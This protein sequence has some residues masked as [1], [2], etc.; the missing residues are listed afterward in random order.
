MYIVYCIVVPAQVKKMRAELSNLNHCAVP[1]AVYTE[2]CTASIS[3]LVHKI[4][5][6]KSISEILTVVISEDIVTHLTA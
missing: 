1:C 6:S 3:A 5:K 2:F 4:R